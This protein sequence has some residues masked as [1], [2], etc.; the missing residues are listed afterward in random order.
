MNETILLSDGYLKEK[1]ALYKNIKEEFIKSPPPINSIISAETILHKGILFILSG[2]TMLHHSE[3]FPEIGSPIFFNEF[4][5]N[6]SQ[7]S[8]SASNR[9]SISKLKQDDSIGGNS[10]AMRT[11]RA[12]GATD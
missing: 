5:N 7:Y 12:D 1:F 11:P 2:Y 8:D 10:S 6:G 9:F 3:V 4:Q